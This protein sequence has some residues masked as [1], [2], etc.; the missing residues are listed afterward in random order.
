[1][2]GTLLSFYVGLTLITLF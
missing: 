2:K 1:M